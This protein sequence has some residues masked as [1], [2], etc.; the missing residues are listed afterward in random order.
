MITGRDFEDD[1]TG[2]GEP[3]TKQTRSTTMV[4]DKDNN[5]LEIGATKE[6]DIN[7]I[8]INKL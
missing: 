4:A 8:S 5:L 1:S 3:I 6:F 7:N 2:F